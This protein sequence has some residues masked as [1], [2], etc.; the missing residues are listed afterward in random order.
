MRVKKSLKTWAEISHPRIIGPF[1]FDG[2]V[3]ADSYLQMIT[4]KIYPAFRRLNNPSDI[5]FMQDGAKKNQ[6]KS[7][8]EW[9]NGL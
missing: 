4:D 5:V 8:R 3:T 7:E 9:M 2:N 6:A 1:F